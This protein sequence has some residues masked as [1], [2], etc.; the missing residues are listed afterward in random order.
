MS[1]KKNY[2]LSKRILKALDAKNYRQ[3][4]SR[5]RYMSLN[6]LEYFYKKVV[7]P[8]V[9]T[10][11]KKYLYNANKT[12]LES[13]VYTRSFSNKLDNVKISKKIKGRNKAIIAITNE[14][15]ARVK[16]E[17][18]NMMESDLHRDINFIINKTK[19]FMRRKNYK[20]FSNFGALINIARNRKA[21]KGHLKCLKKL[22]PYLLVETGSTPNNGKY[23]VWVKED[24]PN[25][26]VVIGPSDGVEDMSDI[27]L[28]AYLDQRFAALDRK[29]KLVKNE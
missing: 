11:W 29:K 26:K 28:E 2:L 10:T 17:L 5:L 15:F 13:G 27:E 8:F 19:S 7:V 3:A 1:S 14:D 16:K 20:R 23:Y 21:V 4:S 6:Q 22:G 18:E 9:A 24:D 25:Q 12:R